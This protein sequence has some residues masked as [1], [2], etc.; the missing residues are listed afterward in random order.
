MKQGV[1]IGTM[2]RWLSGD[3]VD[4]SKQKQGIG[5]VLFKVDLKHSQACNVPV[6]AFVVHS[7][8]WLEMEAE[9]RCI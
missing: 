9:D 1:K 4:E 8:L 2:S 6:V 7:P 5:G 3:S